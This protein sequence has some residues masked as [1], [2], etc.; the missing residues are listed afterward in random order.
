MKKLIE[1]DQKHVYHF[2]KLNQ[3]TY[4]TKSIIN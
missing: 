2:K 1:H 4:H 3:Q